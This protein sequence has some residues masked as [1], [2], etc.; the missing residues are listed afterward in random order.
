ML[1]CCMGYQ[2][3]MM[4]ISHGPRWT[5]R[6]R[7]I[8]TLTSGE[9]RDDAVITY[10]NT[11]GSPNRGLKTL[12]ET[13]KQF[14]HF[15]FWHLWK[16]GPKTCMAC[17]KW[18]MVLKYP[19]MNQIKGWT[20]E[21]WSLKYLKIWPDCW[22]FSMIPERFSDWLIKLTLAPEPALHDSL[23]TDAVEKCTMTIIENY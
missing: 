21:R 23:R 3:I 8:L 6:L 17:D 2:G 9:T 18:D 22:I 7:D 20:N 16:F 15:W 1:Y 5:E 10:T 14:S 12:K 4:G 13:V 19:L 11:P